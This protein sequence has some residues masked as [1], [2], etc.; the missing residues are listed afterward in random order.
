MPYFLDPSRV[1][2]TADSTATIAADNFQ[3]K[4]DDLQFVIA[5]VGVLNPMIMNN[6][7]YI[8]GNTIDR[9]MARLHGAGK[10]NRVYNCNCENSEIRRAKAAEITELLAAKLK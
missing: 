10:T 4:R 1:V 6:N 8:S 3:T 5:A 2:S 7:T 9:L